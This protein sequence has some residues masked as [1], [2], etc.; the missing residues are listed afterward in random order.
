MVYELTAC[1]Y[2]FRLFGSIF[3]VYITGQVKPSQCSTRGAL[4]CAKCKSPCPCLLAITAFGLVAGLY[5]R[6]LNSQLQTK[7][8]LLTFIT[9]LLLCL[10]KTA[11]N[12]WLWGGTAPRLHNVSSRYMLVVSLFLG[13]KW[14]FHRIG[15]DALRKESV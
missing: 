5:N 9:Y 15:S 8:P 6:H 4:I 2:M 12:V 7:L 3:R 10:I 13:T 11:R 14:V 1:S